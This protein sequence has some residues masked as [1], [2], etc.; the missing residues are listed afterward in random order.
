MTSQK[1]NPV[2]ELFASVQLALFL[3]FLL[4]ATS[5]IGTIIPQNNVPQFYIEE[6]GPRTAR[7]LQTLDI[8][9]MYN[10]W[11][12]LFLLTLFALNLIICSLERIPQVIRT[13]SRDGLN[14]SKAQMEKQPLQATLTLSLSPEEAQL[15]IRSLLTAKGWKI[16]EVVREAGVQIFTQKGAWSRFGVYVVHTSILVILGGALLGSAAV[17][18]KIL[19]NP[20]FAF[21]GSIMIPESEASDHILAFKTGRRIDLGFAVRCDAFAIEF[22]DNGMPKTYRTQATILEQ[23]KPVLSSAIQ[24]NT[25]LTYKGITFYQSSYQP[26][27][28]FAIRLKKKD[29][30]AEHTAVIPPA[31]ERQW[32]EGQLSYGIINRE[33]QGEVTRRVKIWLNDQQGEPS[34]F[35]LDINKE[36]AIERPSGTYLLTVRQRYATGLQVTKDPGV[37]LVYSGCFLML[38][39]LYCAFFQSH[40]RVYALIEPSGVGSRILLAGNTTKNKLGFDRYFSD[41]IKK[42]EQ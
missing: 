39:G 25:P 23:G 15:K 11:W 6:Y 13:I 32:P 38:I 26:S 22:Y 1:N 40:R 7:L 19:H 31:S 17:A 14:V 37:W 12:F 28:D 33:R 27:Q 35:W 42:L 21:K 16:R 20:Q 10:S 8:P 41:F 2:F 5:I 29:S 34:V 9:D 4:A 18:T 36:A 30:Q 3:L 24:V